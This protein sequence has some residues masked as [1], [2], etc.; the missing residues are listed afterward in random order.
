MI[1]H[2]FDNFPISM[3]FRTHFSIIQFR[4]NI[5]NHVQF[6]HNGFCHSPNEIKQSPNSLLGRLSYELR[7]NVGLPLSTTKGFTQLDHFRVSG[8]SRGFGFIAW[9]SLVYCLCC[10]IV[11]KTGF[12][13]DDAVFR[14]FRKTFRNYFYDMCGGFEHIMYW[15][16]YDFG[17]DDDSDC[18]NG[19]LQYK[20]QRM[21]WSHIRFF[22]YEIVE[23]IQYWKKSNSF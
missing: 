14:D 16:D 23:S 2:Q 11:R 12:G 19:L 22:G 3:L 6:P 17:C 8:P 5:Q 15:Y 9:M 7:F 21:W 10:G 20:L 1:Y 4:N 18:E 13:L